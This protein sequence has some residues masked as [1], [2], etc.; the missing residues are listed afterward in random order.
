MSSLGEAAGS[1]NHNK[2][3]EQ[4]TR[5][6][7]RLEFL[8]LMQ[9][10][11]GRTVQA[12]TLEGNIVNCEFEEV[13][14]PVTKFGVSNLVMPTGTLDRA[15]LRINDFDYFRFPQGKKLA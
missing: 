2:L 4:S 1:I 10:L 13:D 6:A 11:K 14:R 3:E 8:N 5:S 7:A 12:K 9:I 15:I